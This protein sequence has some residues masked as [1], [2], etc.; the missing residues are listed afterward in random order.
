M[1][2][3]LM[4]VSSGIMFVL[5]SSL[6]LASSAYT[7]Y[8]GSGDFSLTT[9]IDF[10]STNTEIHTGCEGV[11]A[12]CCCPD[13]AGS[14]GG[15]QYVSTDPKTMVD[16]ATTEDGCVEQ[17][18]TVVDES[19]SKTTYTSYDTVMNG[20]GSASTYY[21]EG[22]AYQEAQGSGISYV[23]TTQYQ[24][25]NGNYNY[26][27]QTSGM[28]MNDGTYAGL[29]SYYDV[30]GFPNYQYFEMYL[31]GSNTYGW[32]YLNS[33]DLLNSNLLLLM[34]DN[35]FWSANA[36][37]IGNGLFVTSSSYNGDTYAAGETEID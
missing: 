11:S 9:T 17:H 13:C 31:L 34:G 8:A 25:T 12:C 23:S 10:V 30:S 14:Y 28:S 2:M 27:T 20:T 18:Q 5:L 3:K 15:Q 4:I 29:L 7:E 21:Y 33:T 16:T 35:I 24:E 32:F 36:Q 22:S 1:E 19:D 26:L 37:V 6:A